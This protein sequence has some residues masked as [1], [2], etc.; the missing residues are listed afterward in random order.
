MNTDE[1][2]QHHMKL[3]KHL[4]E[5]TADFIRHTN[6]LPSNTTVL[7]LMQWSHEQTTTPTEET[8]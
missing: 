8:K 7:E 6:G 1:H 2:K 3:H 5:L 4:D